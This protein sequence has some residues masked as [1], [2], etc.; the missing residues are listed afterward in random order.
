MNGETALLA[1]DGDYAPLVMRLADDPALC[2]RIAEN[3]ARDIPVCSWHE[4][5]EQFDKYFEGFVR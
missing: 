1:K 3:A 4:I 5:A 2:R